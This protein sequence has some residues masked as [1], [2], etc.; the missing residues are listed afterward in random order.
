MNDCLKQIPKINSSRTCPFCNHEIKKT[1]NKNFVVYNDKQKKQKEISRP[2][3]Y[4]EHCDLFYISYKQYSMI[5]KIY[6]YKPHRFEIKDEYSLLQV[7]AKSYTPPVWSFDFETVNNKSIPEKVNKEANS[8]NA[9]SNNHTCI[10]NA[11]K[12]KRLP[13]VIYKINYKLQKCPVCEHKLMDFVNVVPISEHN[14]ISFKGKFCALCDRFYEDSGFNIEKIIDQNKFAKEYIVKFDYNIPTY[15]DWKYRF[16]QLD[17]FVCAAFLKET[18]T[19]DYRCITIVESRKEV[20]FEQDI[21]HYS[22]CISR[23]ILTAMFYKRRNIKLEDK[24]YTVVKTYADDD[25]TVDEFN[26]FLKDIKLKKGGGYI[27]NNDEV[28]DV[29]LYSPFTEN[30]EVIRASYN[31]LEDEYYMDMGI[32]RKFINTYGNPGLPILFSASDSSNDFRFQFLKEESLLHAYG[33]NV[34]QK[35]NLSNNYRRVLLSEIIDLELMTPYEIISLLNY[36]INSHSSYKYMNARI[37]WKKDIEFVSNYKINP[38]RFIIA[39]KINK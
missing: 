24:A 20:D 18:E 28:V 26:F 8:N 27:N 30:F 37:K 11:D 12:L 16:S 15:N 1:V 10:L 34:S 2:L 19:Q 31:Q 38:D 36:N 39:D 3:F 25:I 21:F 33:Y 7:R 9:Q 22:D 29:L 13:K 35:D 6:G 32:F 23:R 5:C 4:C 17:S 14:G